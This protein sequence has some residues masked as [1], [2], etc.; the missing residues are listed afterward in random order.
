MIDSSRERKA[1]D[2]PPVSFLEKVYNG[3]FDQSSFRSFRSPKSSKQ[4]EEIL[5]KYQDL[6]QAYPS[7]FI[8]EKG[9]IPEE[10]LG[11]MKAMGLFGLTIP[12]IY[13][14]M[15]FDLPEYLG[16]VERIAPLDLSVALVFLA[17]LFIGVKGIELFGNESQKK[18]YLPAAASGERIFSYALT[19]PRIGSD[20]KHI[21][22][23]AELG[24]NQEEY[25][26]NGVK[27]LITNANYAGG[28]IVFAQMDPSRPGFMGA[29]IVETGWEGVKIGK[30]MP[31]MGIKASSTAAI[32]LQ[33]VRVP[34]ANL[35]GEP[36]KGFKIA[37]TVLNYGRLGL[38][39]ASAGLMGKS[40]EEMLQRSQSRIQFGVPIQDF[41]LIQEKII[42]AKVNHYIMQAMNGFG[43]GLLAVDPRHNAV[44]ETSHCKLFGTT[45]GWEAIYD[46]LQ[47]AGGSGYLSTLPYE[48]R[49][50]DFRVGTVF[51]GTTEIHSFYPALFLLGR[52][53][54]KAEILPPLVRWVFV[55]K[56]FC[57]TFFPWKWNLKYA[58]KTMKKA[59]RLAQS[60]ARKIRRMLWV[61]LIVYGKKAR[62]KEFFLRRIT[63]L[64]LYLF[65]ILAAIARISQ[66]L[67]NGKQGQLDLDLLAF[68]LE[69]ARESRVKNRR[70]IDTPKEKLGA[71]I[72]PRLAKE[73]KK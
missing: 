15:G 28:V 38:G 44:L 13:G 46:A 7:S 50:R 16:I 35:L 8:E 43:A 24:E 30:D 10:M 32:Q 20:A 53:G 34:A 25:I 67:R 39:A 41:P 33:K 18:K 29:F 60:N 51:E 31:K 4:I 1:K 26:L 2:M 68:F 12:E 5:K 22:T 56:E 52:L 72:F 54:K 21:E 70:V 48:K 42:R 73:I 45:R 3:I 62:E 37:M 49:T 23:R 19:E 36:G 27:T 63:T 66:D 65:A 58:D 59:V 40:Y 47:V 17:H 61:G 64:S 9:R 69:E 71:I 11:K 57:R 6:L 14:G 55:L